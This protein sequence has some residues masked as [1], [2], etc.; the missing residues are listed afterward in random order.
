[1]IRVIESCEEI[2]LVPI[3]M[4]YTPRMTRKMVLKNNGKHKD[5]KKGAVFWVL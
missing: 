1:M 5:L 2:S 4:K 3:C